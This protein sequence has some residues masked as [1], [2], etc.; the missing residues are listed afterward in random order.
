MRANDESG[1]GSSCDDAEVIGY[2]ATFF[3]FYTSFYLIKA[4][5]LIRP[6]FPPDSGLV[7]DDC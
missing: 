5:L 6:Y 4:A 3:P 2:M 7:S 1:E